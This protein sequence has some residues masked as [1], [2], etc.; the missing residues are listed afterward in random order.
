MKVAILLLAAGRGSRFGGEVPKAYVPLDGMPIL[1]RSARRL[2]QA[3]DLR[4]PGNRMVVLV[5]PSDR[6]T[7][8]APLLTGLQALGNVVVADGGAT[9]QESMTRGL[10]AAGTDSD[11]V[12]VHDAAR[13]LFPV[14]ATRTA[15]ARAAECG[16]ALLAIPATDT[17][18]RV[19]AATRRVTG[20]VDRASTWLAQTPQVL[21]RDVLERALAQARQ[22]GF[23]GTDDVSLAEHVGCPVAVVEG[24]TRNLKITRSD[25]LLVASALL[26][27]G[28]AP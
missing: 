20:A 9:R 7:H 6:P 21:R 17:L 2:A 27:A 14:A 28:D 16:A 1:L 23:E 13:P 4:A 5:H 25:D 3:V 8:L 15:M 22:D 26:A 12:L 24:S 10:A 11:L 19:D 18:K